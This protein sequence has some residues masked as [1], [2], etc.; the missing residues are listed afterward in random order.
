MTLDDAKRLKPGDVV[1]LLDDPHRP[2]IPLRVVR[3]YKDWSHVLPR[4]WTVSCEHPGWGK[5]YPTNITPWNLGRAE[6]Q[7][8]G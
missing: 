2:P 8:C 3:E 6:F 1:L 7:Q 4:W 5:P